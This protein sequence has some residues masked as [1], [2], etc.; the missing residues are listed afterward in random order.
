MVQ[1]IDKTNEE[2]IAM[3]AAYAI[4]STRLFIIMFAGVFG[5]LIP[6]YPFPYNV[7]I[8]M[9]AIILMC[10]GIVYKEIFTAK[11]LPINKDEVK[12]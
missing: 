4:D 3:L 1:S 8:G 2:K 12:T 11:D 9:L 10:A 7:L 5:L 6:L